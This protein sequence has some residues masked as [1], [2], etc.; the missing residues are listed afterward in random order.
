M[1][2]DQITWKDQVNGCIDQIN[3]WGDNIEA[4]TESYKYE[5]PEACKGQLANIETGVKHI[6]ASLKTIRLI[7]DTEKGTKE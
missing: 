6:L 1:M 3:T 5:T 2:I 4:L 7:L